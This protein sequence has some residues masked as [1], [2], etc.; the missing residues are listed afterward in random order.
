MLRPYQVQAID[1]IRA[2]FASGN[3]KI[4]LHMATGTGKTVCFC[5]MVKEALSREKRSI[6]VVRGKKLVSQASE[7]LARENV[8]HG[9]Q[10]GNHPKYAPER[11]VQV[12]SITTLH[13]RKTAPKADLV[14]IDEC[15]FGT[16]PEFHWLVEQYPKAFILGVTATPYCTKPLKHL[17]DKVVSPIPIL[18]VIKQ[19]F[20][21]DARYYAPSKP[22]LSG[23][24]I[25][26]GDYVEADLDRVMSRS[27]I[28]GDI[29]ENYRKFSD[30]LSALCFCVSVAHATL[31]SDQFNQSGI[32]STVLHAGSPDSIRDEAITGLKTGDPIVICNVGVMGVGVDIP[33][34]RTI[35]MARPT[36]SL[37]LYLQQIG[38]GTR[39]YKDKNHF[40]V[41]DHAGNV[42]QHG[43]M[44]DER[45]PSLD[46]SIV[47]KGPPIKTC[48]KCF[49]IFPVKNNPVACPS[50]CK[51]W[52]EALGDVAPRKLIPDTKPGELVEIRQ[53]DALK[54]SI[55]VSNEIALEAIQRIRFHLTENSTRIKSDGQPYSP[56]A[57]YYQT[58]KEMAGKI[59]EE[60]LVRLFRAE[61]RIKGFYVGK[62]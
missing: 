61:A 29:V 40:L 44:T 27:K 26:A 39:P 4:L 24:R 14:I 55:Q 35:I 56:W 5:Y 3:R 38:R 11:Y 16:A 7:R 15:H 22:D 41:L 50:C 48:K 36:K 9:V 45:E 51:E 43:F 62:N 2:E 1:Q 28:I 17:A 8:P 47:G 54:K 6:I 60:A 57:A 33:W 46:G 53:Q 25:R 32:K 19:G 10:M 20:L 59:D 23:V 49:A 13:K 58:Q 18:E 37:N 42:E 31:V 21:V 52:R 12:C 30:G 34:L